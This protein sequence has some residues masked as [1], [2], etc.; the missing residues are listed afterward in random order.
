MRALSDVTISN[1][2]QEPKEEMKVSRVGG[3]LSPTEHSDDVALAWRNAVIVTIERLHTGARQPAMNTPM[4]PAATDGANGSLMRPFT[5]WARTQPNFAARV[6]R[7]AKTVR[8]ARNGARE[9]GP[10][11]RRGHQLEVAATHQD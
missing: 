2:S 9:P 4:R 8:I 11:E 5:C 7:S 1:A 10:Q 3:A 6:C